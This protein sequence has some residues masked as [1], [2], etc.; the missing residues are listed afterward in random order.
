MIFTEEQRKDHDFR[1]KR[2]VMYDFTRHFFE[3]MS[4]PVPIAVQI[5]NILNANGFKFKDDGKL[6]AVANENPEPE[7]VLTRWEDYETGSVF[8]KQELNR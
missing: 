1:V 2:F 3:K 8:Y 6:G 4:G 5:R 7:G